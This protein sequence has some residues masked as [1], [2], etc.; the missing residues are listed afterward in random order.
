MGGGGHG[1]VWR[2]QFRLASASG[3]PNLTLTEQN[4]QKIERPDRNSLS[5][6]VRNRILKATTSF[7]YFEVFERNAEP[8]R[9]AIEKIESIQKA[10]RNLIRT[11]VALTSDPKVYADHLVKVGISMTSVLQCSAV[12]CFTSLA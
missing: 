2:R 11:L 10:T 3:K 4:W 12:I 5:S 9:A 8:L 1:E 7:V 6:D